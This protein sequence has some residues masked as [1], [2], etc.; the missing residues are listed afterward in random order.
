MLTVQLP[1]PFVLTAIH[2]SAGCIGTCFLLCW[3]SFTPKTLSNKDSLALFAFSVLY[4]ANIAVSNLSLYGRL[5]RM[6][7]TLVLFVNYLSVDPWLAF[8]YTKSS[9]PQLRSSRSQSTVSASPALMEFGLIY[10]WSLSS[11]A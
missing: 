8:L 3:G 2:A 1:S 7:N 10:P 6:K 9:A 5:H 4:T 11:L